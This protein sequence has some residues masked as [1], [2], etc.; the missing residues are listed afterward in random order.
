M[1]TTAT[2]DNF[3]QILESD[4]PVLVDFWAPWCPPCRAVAPVIDELATEYEG[5]AQVV[6]I[7]VDESPEL[8]AKYGVSSIP[9]FFVFKNGEV[10]DQAVGALTRGALSKLIDEQLG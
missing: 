6:K 8:A 7:D 1:A 9:A 4:Q 5:R 2:A 10:Q 3:A